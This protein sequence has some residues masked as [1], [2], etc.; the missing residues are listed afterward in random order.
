[1]FQNGYRQLR[2]KHVTNIANTTLD[3]WGNLGAFIN[4]HPFQM[5]VTVKIMGKTCFINSQ[6][7]RHRQ[8]T[9]TKL[10]PR[11]EVNGGLDSQPRISWYIRFRNVTR[12]WFFSPA[13]FL[14]PSQ[15]M[16][17][18]PIPN[19]KKDQGCRVTK[20]YQRPREILTS[21][22]LEGL[23]PLNQTHHKSKMKKQ[24]HL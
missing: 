21:P 16:A 10:N 8:E 9:M 18:F 7:C 23:D 11:N 17:H 15:I 4:I 20:K 13:T 2:K 12:R 3:I 6:E 5:V 19:P 22:F 14:H 24:S 1:M